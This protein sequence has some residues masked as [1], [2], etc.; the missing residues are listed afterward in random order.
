MLSNNAKLPS[1]SNRSKIKMKKYEIR[2][3]YLLVIHNIFY[4]HLKVC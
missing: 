1:E 3:K 2:Y 4:G